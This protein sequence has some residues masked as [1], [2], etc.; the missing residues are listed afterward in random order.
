[1]LFLLKVENLFPYEI[2][3][4][5]LAETSKWVTRFLDDVVDANKYVP[6]VC[7]LEEA[8]KK[9]R[10]I[11]VSIMGLADM[12]YLVGVRYGSRQGED[13]AGQVMEFKIANE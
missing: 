1:M 7:Q 6:A 10:R 4:A 3:W 13:L 12:M 5:K 2:D 9:N 11:G 8:A